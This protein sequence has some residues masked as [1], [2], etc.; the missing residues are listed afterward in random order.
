MN[1]FVGYVT[2]YCDNGEC[3]AREFTVHV[4]LYGN[5]PAR[6]IRCPFCSK[7]VRVNKVQTM[8]EYAE[9][10]RYEARCNVNVQRYVRRTGVCFLPMSVWA[11]DSL[12][13]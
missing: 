4:K 12:P 9:D 10:R 5:F 1:Y 3:R 6:G 2:A 7:P 13:D 8:E 11:D